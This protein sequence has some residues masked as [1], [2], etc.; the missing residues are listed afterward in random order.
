MSCSSSKDSALA[1]WKEPSVA[2]TPA[3]MQLGAA[4]VMADGA[5]ITSSQKP[6]TTIF[7][8]AIPVSICLCTSLTLSALIGE[9]IK[10]LSS[11]LF[12]MVMDDGSLP[13]Y[14]R[15]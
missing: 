4:T 7:P 14:I 11:C 12:P 6:S 1:H 9:S 8:F 15:F 3:S 13:G 10:C 5:A 2:S